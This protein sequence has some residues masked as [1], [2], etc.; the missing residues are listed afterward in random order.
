MYGVFGDN[1]TEG[2]VAELLSGNWT[3]RSS[4]FGMSPKRVKGCRSNE[5]GREPPS[6]TVGRV[7]RE[8]FVDSRSD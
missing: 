8:E 7:L 3:P 1:P 5:T 4:A 2:N 6:R